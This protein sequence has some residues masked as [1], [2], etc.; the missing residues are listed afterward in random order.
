MPEDLFERTNFGEVQIA[1]G[2]ARL[3]VRSVVVG[4]DVVRDQFVGFDLQVFEPLQRRQLVFLTAALV[5][6]ERD[7]D[8]VAA[9]DRHDEAGLDQ[10]EVIP[11]GGFDLHLFKRRNLDVLAGEQQCDFGRFVR[12]G[13]EAKLFGIAVLPARLVDKLQFHAVQAGGDEVGPMN[14]RIGRIGSQRQRDSVLVDQFRRDPRLVQTTGNRD[15]RT[16]DHSRHEGIV[17][18]LGFQAGVAGET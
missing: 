8:R 12:P 6:S 18:A 13:F 5:L 4:I 10:A 3:A 14:Q 7:C 11:R 15:R 9:R 16:L 17:Q 1:A 2:A